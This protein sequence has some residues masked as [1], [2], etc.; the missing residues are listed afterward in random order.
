MAD[1]SHDPLLQPL[2]I[3]KLRLKNRIMSTSHAISYGVEGLPQERYQRYHE[4]KARGGIALT[5]FGGS[6]TISPDSP[7]VFGQLDVSNDA[8]IPVFRQFAERIHSYDAGLMCQITHMGRRTIHHGGNWLAPIAPSRTPGDMYGGIPKEMDEDDIARVIHDFGQAARRCYEGGLDGCEVI[9]TGHLLDQFWTPRVNKR[10]DKWGGS[11]EN[12]TRFSRLVY[13]EMRRQTSEDFVLSL[14]MTTD[15][16]TPDGLSKADCLEIAK[17]H[18]N[19]GLIDVLNL[20]H[21]SVDTVR[22]L[23]NYMPG[24]A[25]PLS[26]FL[27]TVRA[28]RDVVEVPIFSRNAHQRFGDCAAWPPR[29]TCRHGGYHTRSHRGSSHR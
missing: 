20:V 23:A 18:S 28:F 12:R 17:L 19:A 9:A 14:R 11:L 5:M 29:G 25:L 26:P 16:A 1:T 24:M 13:E 15:E 22:G 7:S 27:E 21:G 4:E 10:Q 8:I 6:S 2:T 3:K